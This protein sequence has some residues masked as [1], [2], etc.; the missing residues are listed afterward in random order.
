MA[1]I[2]QANPTMTR[3]PISTL[4]SCF[5]MRIR[6]ESFSFV[7]NWLGPYSLKRS[8]TSAMVHPTDDTFSL[9]RNQLIVS[10]MVRMCQE[11]GNSSPL[12]VAHNSSS[13]FLITSGAHVLESSILSLV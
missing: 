12:K 8:C 10:S 11:G 13:A 6:S 5:H 4:H 2:I 3:I 1:R 7:V 9:S